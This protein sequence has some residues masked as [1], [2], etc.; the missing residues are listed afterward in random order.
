MSDEDFS[1]S[2][3]SCCVV[4]IS[5]DN[6]HKILKKIFEK[7]QSDCERV[8]NILY[9]QNIYQTKIIIHHI[10]DVPVLCIY[11]FLCFKNINNCSVIN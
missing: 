3:S 5:L 1:H 11:V 6:L 8:Y 2:L 4:N 10:I 9:V 7:V